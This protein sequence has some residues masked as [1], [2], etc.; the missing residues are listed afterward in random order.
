[1][2]TVFHTKLPDARVTLASLDDGLEFAQAAMGVEAAEIGRLH[3][4]FSIHRLQFGATH[5]QKGRP[6][7]RQKHDQKQEGLEYGQSEAGGAQ[8]TASRHGP[9][10]RCLEL[11]G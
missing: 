3:R 8:Q 4:D 1:M 5:D 9:R 2:A 11:C 6:A 10:N 7:G